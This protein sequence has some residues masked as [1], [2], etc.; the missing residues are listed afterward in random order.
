MFLAIYTPK[1]EGKGFQTEAE[2][3][4]WALRQSRHETIEEIKQFYRDNPQVAPAGFEDYEEDAEELERQQRYDPPVVFGFEADDWDAWTTNK[5]IRPV[6]V[7]MRGK[8]YTVNEA[9]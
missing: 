9:G 1:L 4:E 3:D 6:A 7:Y 8:K 2:M 5:Y